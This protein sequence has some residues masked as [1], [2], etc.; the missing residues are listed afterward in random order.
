MEH[1]ERA[2]ALLN[3]DPGFVVT[4]QHNPAAYEARV[5]LG[6]AEAHLESLDGQLD[7]AMAD[8]DRLQRYIDAADTFAKARAARDALQGD[9]SEAEAA[10][11]TRRDGLRKLE[12][13]HT[14]AV[15]ALEAAQT[16][17]AE[18][19]MADVMG[20]PAPATVADPSVLALHARNLEV[21]VQMAHGAV[22][23]QIATVSAI[24]DHLQA[25]QGEMDI[26]DAMDAEVEWVAAMVDCL[27][28]LAR[29]PGT[30]RK[31]HGW[32]SPMPDLDWA[33][34]QYLSTHPGNDEGLMAA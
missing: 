25:A 16:V 6:N 19:L 23:A 10:L 22:A 32:C 7:D 29:H 5:A 26:A 31:A 34:K 14:Q 8:R 2:F 11:Q 20:T 12:S 33:L 9:L 28:K 17:L 18:A 24:R 3:R 27:P 4:R 30:W 13:Q 1:A 15:E 21:S